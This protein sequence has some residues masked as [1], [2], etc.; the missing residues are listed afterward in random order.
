[1]QHRN[2]PFHIYFDASNESLGA[3]L[4]EKE[5]V[6]MHAIYYISKNL[7]NAELNYIVDKKEF[8]EDVT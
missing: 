1:M 3:L 7:A 5:N 6:A 2:L 4:G 8:L